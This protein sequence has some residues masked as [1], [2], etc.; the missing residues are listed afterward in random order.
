MP[1]SIYLE[2]F[3]AV[4]YD[5]F[6]TT[7]FHVG[8]SVEGKDWRDVDVRVMLD[9]REYRRWFGKYTKPQCANAKWNGMCLAF[10]ELGH[11]MTGLPI[12]FQIQRVR[13]ANRQY[14]NRPRNPLGVFERVA[15]AGT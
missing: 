13:E 15:W 8:S 9:G 2:Q 11:R 14:G 5:V 3:G 12:D 4:V 7:P 10:A 6:D 1:A